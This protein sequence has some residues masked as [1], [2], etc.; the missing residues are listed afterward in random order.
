MRERKGTYADELYDRIWKTKG[1][2]FNAYER[3][4]RRQR[5]SFYSTGILS[6]YLIIINLLEPFGLISLPSDSNMV[7]FISVSLSII[8]L[9]FVTIENAADYS[10]KG[11][12]FHNCA[13]DLG[14]I[15][16][17]L[18]SLIEKKES[19]H[20]KYDAIAEKYADI[21]DKYDNHAPIDYEVHKT[22]HSNDFNLNFVHRNWILLRANY[23]IDSHYFAFII[24]PP[25]L[26]S[27]WTLSR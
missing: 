5:R 27:I 22:K 6:A 17:E 7:A 24:L 1:A 13:K 8:L 15:Y 20:S 14:R 16:N 10:L 11:T 9:V 26:F 23:I 12:N 2:R 25:I 4:R 3:L 18:H 21:L 19:D